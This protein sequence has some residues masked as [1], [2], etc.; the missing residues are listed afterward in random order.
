MGVYFIS[1]HEMIVLLSLKH[2]NQQLIALIAEFVCNNMP[3]VLLLLIDDVEAFKIT[4]FVTSHH[5]QGQGK[6]CTH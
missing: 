5:Q 4:A 2:F 1:F 6:V 3:S